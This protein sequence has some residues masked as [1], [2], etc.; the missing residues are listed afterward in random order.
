MGRRAFRP[1]AA[2]RAHHGGSAGTW[3]ARCR[4]CPF[5]HDCCLVTRSSWRPLCLW[6][7]GDGTVRAS[8]SGTLASDRE[9][10][11]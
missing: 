6:R 11:S 3:D 7:V 4:I 2:P 1:P 9:A 5:S 10:P 8:G